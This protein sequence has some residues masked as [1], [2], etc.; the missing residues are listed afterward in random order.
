LRKTR[1]SIHGFYK[2]V[3]QQYPA[4]PQLS[5]E[6]IEE[7][8]KSVTDELLALTKGRVDSA[9]LSELFSRELLKSS[10]TDSQLTVS[11]EIAALRQML[12]KSDADAKF[13][14][15]RCIRESIRGFYKQAQQQD[16]TIAQA[17]PEQ[18][19]RISKAVIEDLLGKVGSDK[20]GKLLGSA[21]EQMNAR[22]IAELKKSDAAAKPALES[23]IRESVQAFYEEALWRQDS[24]VAQLP[25]WD[26]AKMSRSV[27]E[28]LLGKIRRDA[29]IGKSFL[30]TV[31]SS[32]KL[33]HSQEVPALSQALVKLVDS[34][35][36]VALS[37]KLAKFASAAKSALLDH[38]TEPIQEFYEQVQLW[39]QDIHKVSFEGSGSN[40]N[41]HPKETPHLG[42][43]QEGN[44]PPQVSHHQKMNNISESVRDTFLSQAIVTDSELSKSL[45][46]SFEPSPTIAALIA[47]QQQKRLEDA[48]SMD[49]ADNEQWKAFEAFLEPIQRWLELLEQLRQDQ[50]D[51]FSRLLRDPQGYE[52]ASTEK[53]QAYTKRLHD[54]MVEAY[55]KWQDL[56]REKGQSSQDQEMANAA[57]EYEETT[58][59]FQEAIDDLERWSKLKRG[60]VQDKNDEFGCIQQQDTRNYIDAF[61][62][63]QNLYHQVIEFFAKY[64]DPA[65]NSEQLKLHNELV[66]NFQ[67]AITKTEGLQVKV[68][69]ENEEH[70]KVLEKRFEESRMRF[71]KIRKLY[72]SNKSIHSDIE[73]YKRFQE[74][75]IIKREIIIEGTND[76][77]NETIMDMMFHVEYRERYPIYSID[78]KWYINMYGYAKKVHRC[79]GE[80]KEEDLCD[81]EMIARYKDA[82][83]DIVKVTQEAFLA[84]WDETAF[85]EFK[86]VALIFEDIYKKLYPEKQ[87]TPMEL[88]FPQRQR[89]HDR[90]GQ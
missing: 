27:T 65:P 77:K 25:L 41:D 1:E 32:S 57:R 52:A 33:I 56:K 4:I 75:F 24:T 51:G 29:K 16:P 19:E 90:I 82:C 64:P 83:Y 58:K 60:F 49:E 42:M 8:S 70:L 23:C 54:Q 30:A 6:Q 63:T 85:E 45:L 68:K 79:R 88:V 38:M 84:M 74:D 44:N 87:L 40:S 31:G 5:P 21:S 10:L 12:E 18:I 17:L 35:G 76:G 22:A 55:G 73:N 86:R 13:A 50:K 26:I 39:D 7:T 3:R 48:E 78:K 46:A 66:K 28:G 72:G 69:K 47:S 61:K 37:E 43:R 14:L 34:Q 11:Q 71:M 80:I 36:S 89:P 62:D 53:V 15:V 67:A 9:W 2:E 20:F 59:Q 81:S